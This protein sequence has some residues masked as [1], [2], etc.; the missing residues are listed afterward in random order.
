MCHEAPAIGNPASTEE[1]DL[2]FEVLGDYGR[3]ALK[4]NGFVPPVL[5]ILSRMDNKEGRIDIIDVRQ[6]QVDELG[7]VGKELIMLFMT[8]TCKQ[9]NV[10]VV[11]HL[12]ETWAVFGT[13]SKAPL[14]S[15]LKDAPG[16][17][18]ALFFNL[19]SAECQA[20][21]LWPMVLADA[22]KI[23]ESQPLQFVVDGVS[24]HGRFHRDLK[25]N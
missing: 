10:R 24:F 18:E 19:M 11:G 15:S 2:L 1:F 8:E 25:K 7:V 5:A 23:T 4:E 3:N 22:G 21:A 17:Q 14:P 16:R 20:F 6:L 12:T 9:A 13:D